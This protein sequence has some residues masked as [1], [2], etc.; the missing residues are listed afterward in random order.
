MSIKSL[1]NLERIEPRTLKEN[2]TDILRQSIINGSLAPGTELNQVQIAEQLG[3]SRGPVREALGQLEQEGL[4]ESVPYKGVVITSLTRRY[5]EEIYEVRTV[6]EKLAIDRAIDRMEDVQI[7]EL[8]LIVEEMRQAARAEDLVRLVELDL[9]FHEYIL[10]Q[11][12]HQLAMKLW[13]L[14]E[15]GVQ[16]CLHV[17]HEIYTFLD[18]V[19]GSHP[20][21]VT[22]I[23]NRD[24][25]LAF[26]IL[27][28]HIN[29]S[30]SHILENLPE[31][32]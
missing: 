4:I 13:K 11:S 8:D 20:T 30:A 7:E 1:D 28:E 24:K 14:L 29:E 32:E 15:V 27:D 25:E 17:R 10:V 19:V 2:V 23:K 31:E 5:V 12:D 9:A 21:L 6:L 3:T 16:R 22:A 18:Q 26:Q